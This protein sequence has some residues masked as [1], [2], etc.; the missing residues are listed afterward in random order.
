M[1]RALIAIIIIA[2]VVLGGSYF[3]E[4]ETLEYVAPEP[5]TIEKIVEVDTLDKRI[6]DAQ[7]AEAETIKSAGEKAKQNAETQMLEEI[8]LEVRSVYGKELDAK[9]LELKKKQT[10]Y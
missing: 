3:F 9:E 5:K 1:K 10:S 8:E 2:V 7:E 4:F 6:K